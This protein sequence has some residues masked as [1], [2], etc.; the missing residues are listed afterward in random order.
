VT[1]VFID[2][3]IDAVITTGMHR[4][5]HVLPLQSAVLC[6]RIFTHLTFIMELVFGL[7]LGKLFADRTGGSIDGIDL[8]GTGIYQQ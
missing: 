8:T 6:H 4:F 5:M 7:V 2:D 1:P 3:H